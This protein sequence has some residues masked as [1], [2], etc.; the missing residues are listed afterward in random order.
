MKKKQQASLSA[1][2]MTEDGRQWVTAALDPFHDSRLKVRGLPDSDTSPSLIQVIEKSTSISVPSGSTNWAFHVFTLPEIHATT[3]NQSMY[4][5]GATTPN[6]YNPANGSDRAVDTAGNPQATWIVGD[7]SGSGTAGQVVGSI[8]VWA[9]S[10]DTTAPM[11]PNGQAAFAPPASAISLTPLVISESDIGNNCSRMRIISKGF[12][13]R[14]TTAELYKQGTLTVSRVP[15]YNRIQTLPIVANGIINNYV[16]ASPSGYRGTVAENTHEICSAPPATVSEALAYEGSKQWEASKGV[17]CVQ[18]MDAERNPMV[19]GSY[20]RRGFFNN[21]TVKNP[22]DGTLANNFASGMIGYA[23]FIDTT[24]GA[25]WSKQ[26]PFCQSTPFD[27]SSVL[28]TGLSNQTTF[29]LTVKYI[30]EVAPHANDPGYKALVYSL[31]PS[32][33]QDRVAL[34]LYQL[35]ASQLPVGVPVDMNG[36]GEFFEIIRSLVAKYGPAVSD[37]L[38]AIPH[39]VAQAA[40]QVVS[41]ASKAAQNAAPKQLKAPQPN[42]PRGPNMK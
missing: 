4:V 9:W 14:N 36:S 5:N 39:P 35:I 8:N 16:G 31:T 38:R 20:L 15:S 17:Y 3:M 32:P 19:Q 23:Q 11:Y 34:R 26:V 21:T 1:P 10:T 24:S 7:G 27:I 37:V 41:A 18:T 28:A 6:I 25:A 13:L 40:A 22:V 29:T 33:A 12:E 30:V 42:P 2:G